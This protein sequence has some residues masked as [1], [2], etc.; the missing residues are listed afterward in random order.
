MVILV[1]V[2]VGTGNETKGTFGKAIAHYNTIESQRR[3]SLHTHF[4]VWLEEQPTTS[5]LLEAIA[6]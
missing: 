3:V 1:D 6:H 4:L 2:L 5:Q